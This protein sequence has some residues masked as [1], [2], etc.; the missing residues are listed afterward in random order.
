MPWP[1]ARN[2]RPIKNNPM[3][4]FLVFVRK[5][6]YHVFRDRRTLL[7]LFGLPIV[8]ILLFGF[9]LTTEVKNARIVVVDYARDMASQQIITRI[10]GSP[11]FSIE[12][13]AL[14]Y[15]EMYKAFRE[16]RVKCAL[17]F[18][19]G[20]NEDLLHSSKAHV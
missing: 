13:A 5:E 18:P 9:A 17:V 1:A 14:S 7:I 12:K 4:Q 16:G 19:A 20:F 2:A 6:F 8:Q 10:A 15:D 3:K 11:Y